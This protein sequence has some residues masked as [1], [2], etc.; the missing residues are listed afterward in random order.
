MG[1]RGGR[2]EPA[3]RAF[4]LRAPARER[5]VETCI[6][7]CDRCPLSE[8]LQE[9]LVEI[10]ELSALAL[11]GQV[12]IAVGLTAD[13][14]GNSQEGSHRRVARRKPVGARMIVDVAQPQWARIAN[15]LPEQHRRALLQVDRLFVH[16]HKEK[17]LQLALFLVEDT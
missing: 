13:R 16:A 6:V 2:L 7:D 15:Q 10:V 11:L 3:D 14:Y 8:H 17:A 9:L 4:E 5:L 1:R 12:E